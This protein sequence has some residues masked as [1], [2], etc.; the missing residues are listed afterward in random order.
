VVGY[1]W[2]FEETPTNLYILHLSIGQQFRRQHLGQA[3]IDALATRYP[4]METFTLMVSTQNYPGLKFWLAVGFEHLCYVEAPD[5]NAV[6]SAVELEL[7][8]QLPSNT[9]N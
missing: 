6:T 8:K 9:P 4:Q 7:Q 1:V 2:V 3:T 5:E